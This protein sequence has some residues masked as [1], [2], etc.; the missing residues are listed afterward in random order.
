ML[1]DSM[2]GLKVVISPC[3]TEFVRWRR[4]NRNDRIARKWR[5]RFGAVTRCGNKSVFHMG[6]TIYACRCLD[7]AIRQQ[8]WKS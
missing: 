2:F 7:R 3:L 1:S 4:T 8:E 5:K 6:N